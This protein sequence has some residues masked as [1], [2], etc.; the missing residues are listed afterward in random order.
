VT[1]SHRELARLCDIIVRLRE[2]AGCPWDREQTERSMAPHL[3]EETYEAIDAIER[4]DAEAVCEELGDVLMNVLMIARIAGETGRFDREDVARGIADKLVRRHPHVFGDAVADD[5]ETVLRNWEQI[6][7]A[8]KRER[9]PT[10]PTSALS[11]VP[12]ALPA[13]LRAFRI[14][15]KAARVGFDWPDSRG[16]R[17]KVDEELRELDA[18]LASGDET[19]V[20]AELGDALFALVNLARHHAIDP[21]TAL[22]ATIAKFQSR[23]A[24]VERSLGDR[25]RDAPLDEK[26]AL[27]RDAKDLG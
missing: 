20:R 13:L 26:E 22:R 19:A 15:E 14:G 1:E 21:E 25:L 17:A 2:P 9:A 16:P 3:L 10:E 4:G 18:A 12:E 27:W 7:V 24:H 23:F 8:E 5:A 11:G 6:K